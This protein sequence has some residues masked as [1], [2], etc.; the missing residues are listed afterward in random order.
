MNQ[1]SGPI[2]DIVQA[3]SECL[4]I[5]A[6]GGGVQLTL[7]S[8][9][10]GGSAALPADFRCPC[11]VSVGEISTS[12]VKGRAA[13]VFRVP[14]CLVYVGLMFGMDRSGVEHRLAGGFA[15]EDADAFGEA[16]NQC[17][18]RIAV[19][20]GA[21]LGEEVNARHLET[22]AV[23]LTPGSLD[24]AKLGLSGTLQFAKMD[25]TIQGHDRS[26][27]LLVCPAGLFATDT[28]IP[29]VQFDAAPTATE[30]RPPARP[31]AART[32]PAPAN[33]PRTRD[34]KRAMKIR[35]P[36]TVLLAE[37]QMSMKEV[38]QLAPGSI[39]E[40]SKSSEEYLDLVVGDRKFAEGEA[41]KTGD[42]FCFQVKRISRSS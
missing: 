23:D 17:F 4:D 1:I 16:M 3:V 15:A 30:A 25:L 8:I 12:R 34:V 32:A 40:F 10:Q 14:D 13:F 31:T 2:V 41:A 20:G 42:K 19:A 37:K 21:A 18:G 22:R 11:V 38:F 39:I 6:D 33:Q 24:A 9:D 5:I 26:S 36:I 35:L 28:A 29:T 7:R 27:A